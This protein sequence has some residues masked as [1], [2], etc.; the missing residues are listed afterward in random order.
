MVVQNE[1][2][3]TCGSFGWL[4]LT[5][6]HYGQHTQGWLWPVWQAEFFRDLERVHDQSGPWDFVLFSGDL[7]YSGQPS[8]FQALT[9]MLRRLWEWIGKKQTNTPNLLAVPGNHDLQR[10]DRKRSAASALRQYWNDQTVQSE[11]WA[12]QENEYRQ[13]MQA[14]FAAYCDWLNALDFGRGFTVQPGLLPGDFAVTVS[15]GK[16]NLGII[17]LN[18]TFLQLEGGDYQGKLDLHPQQLHAVCGGDATTW[19]DQHHVCFLVTHQPY[20]WLAPRAQE[21]FR[22][23]VYPTDSFAAHFHGHMH[24]RSDLI[25][26][27]GG[28]L[29]RRH[30]QGCS[31][32]GLEHY[33][34]GID[35]AKF[36][37]AAGRLEVNRDKAALYLWP[38]EGRKQQSGDVRLVADSTSSL[39]VGREHLPPIDVPL[40]R[41]CGSSVGTVA[42]PAG[43]GEHTPSKNPDPAELLRIQ[44]EAVEQKLQELDA[45]SPGL[46]HGERLRRLGEI[47]A[48]FYRIGSL[49]RATTVMTGAFLTQHEHLEANERISIGLQ[50]AQYL[51]E[52]NQPDQAAP[53][54]SI[55]APD[56]DRLPGSDRRKSQY[57]QLQSRCWVALSSYE[58]AVQAI[59]R[60][61]DVTA[62]PV[63]SARLQAELAEI[64]FLQGNL[65]AVSSP[66]AAGNT[67][68]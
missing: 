2:R 65:D 22:G 56:A 30:F 54:L 10:P 33:G 24:E 50:L 15:Q 38:R 64:H 3:G 25:I 52:D 62:D 58:A 61:I 21:L 67:H 4:W 23:I 11:F 17:G 19:M 44:Q 46:A 7:V 32:F 28:A 68:D 42:A 16:A 55:V 60:A 26:A 53:V 1:Q 35:R 59:T 31:L 51:L 12:A 8:E 39:A 18:S 57:W 36:G 34:D 20:D 66:I 37:Y 14:A 5:D 40:R 47:S 29:P 45:V 63:A 48:D 43:V 49:R 9:T 6:F 27:Q 41:I 13:L